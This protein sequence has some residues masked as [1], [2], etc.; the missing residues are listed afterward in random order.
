MSER[1]AFLTVTYGSSGLET[2]SHEKK[3]VRENDVKF[4]GEDG[5]LELTDVRLVWYRKPGSTKKEKLKKFGMIAGA[6]AG[7][8]VLEGMGRQ[9]GGIGGRVVR[10]IGHGIAA[11]TIH[12]AFTSWTA[13]NF[14]NRDANGNTESLAVPIVAIASAAQSGNNL[15]IDLKSGGNMTFAFKQSK[16]IPLVVANINQ[17]QQVGKC[18]YCGAHAGGATSCPKCGAPIESPGGTGRAPA[19]GP[20]S[21]TIQYQPNTGGGFCIN[22]GSPVPAGAKFCGNCGQ[23]L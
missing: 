7:A 2:M 20:A 16:V 9:M 4:D 8:A 3:M 13:D 1:P 23:K 19:V 12:S 14:Y 21:V 10:G 22:C 5:S 11:A 15:V 17:A 18:P 6:I